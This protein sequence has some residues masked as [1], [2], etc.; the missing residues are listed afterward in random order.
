V[1]DGEVTCG[2][3]KDVF[4]CLILADGQGR[5][6][7]SSDRLQH[8]PVI[9]GLPSGAADVL[10]CTPSLVSDKIIS[11]NL[12][13]GFWGHGSGMLGPLSVCESSDLPNP[14]VGHGREPGRWGPR[15]THVSQYAGTHTCYPVVALLIDV[16]M[17]RLV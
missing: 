8:Y 9:S 3:Q 7:Q 16:L 12:L 6:T 5:W 15:G 10:A 1:D 11:K 2:P 13:E 14:L 4:D 17:F